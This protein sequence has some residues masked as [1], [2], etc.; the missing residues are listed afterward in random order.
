MKLLS[1]TTESVA[2]STGVIFARISVS[3]AFHP[4]I[5]MITP[6]LACQAGQEF[7]S[8]GRT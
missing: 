4:Y 7:K 5:Q 1:A 8:P 3:F 6:R 2:A